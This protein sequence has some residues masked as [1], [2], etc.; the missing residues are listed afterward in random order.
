MVVG[1]CSGACATDVLATDDIGTDVFARD[2]VEAIAL[3]AIA[4]DEVG[5]S[6]LIYLLATRSCRGQSLNV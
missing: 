5:H 2:E 3:D 1:E 4:R 6:R